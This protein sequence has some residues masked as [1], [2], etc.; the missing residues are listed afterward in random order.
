MFVSLRRSVGRY[1]LFGN[2]LA[3]RTTRRSLCRDK[4]L[5]F[6]MVTK[7]IQMHARN[8][9]DLLYPHVKFPGVFNPF[10]SQ[11]L[12]EFHVGYPFWK[13]FLSDDEAPV[14]QRQVAGILFFAFLLGHP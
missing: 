13:L 4:A 10:S 7:F 9:Q 5:L 3:F 12:D 6:C 2:A 14:P 1:R 8:F 11:E